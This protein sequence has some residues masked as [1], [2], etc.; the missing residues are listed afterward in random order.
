MKVVRPCLA[1]ASVAVMVNVVCDACGAAA[2]ETDARFCSQCGAA[3][4]GPEGRTDPYSPTPTD[5]LGDPAAPN[6]WVQ[7]ALVTA[8]VAVVVFVVGLLLL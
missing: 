5:A 6:S 2:S 7:F 4:S 8:V 3:L 1:R